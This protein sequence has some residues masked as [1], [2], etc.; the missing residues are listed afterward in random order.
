MPPN[1]PLISAGIVDF[2]EPRLV[3][4]GDPEGFLWLASLIESAW[5]GDLSS[6][7]GKLHLAGVQL[8]IGHS[9]LHGGLEWRGTQLHWRLSNSALQLFPEQLRALAQSEGAGHA[10]LDDPAEEDTSIQAIASKGEY[11]PAT[12]F[13]DGE[14][15]G[16]AAGT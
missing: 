12:L 15:G 16:T 1:R 11:D 10:Y 13:G 14:I 4:V 5:T 7:G 3:I 2:D 9:G 6:L 8:C